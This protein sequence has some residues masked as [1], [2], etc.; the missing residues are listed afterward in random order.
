VSIF[1]VLDYANGEDLR[2]SVKISQA[3][4][5]R[6]SH[7]TIITRKPVRVDGVID[8]HQNWNEYAVH[9]NKRIRMNR[10]ARVG[11]KI[12]IFDLMLKDARRNSTN[13]SATKGTEIV[14]HIEAFRGG[15]L[16][17]AEW[18]LKTLGGDPYVGTIFLGSEPDFV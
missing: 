16:V 13:S 11:A 10:F 1:I 7:H 2:H 12:A 14:E 5:R 15:S 3:L 4:A 6:Y 8:F 17:T 18:R 9:D